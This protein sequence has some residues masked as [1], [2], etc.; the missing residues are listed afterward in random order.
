TLLNCLVSCLP[1]VQLLKSSD[2]GRHSLL[3]LKEIGHGWFGKV[4]LGEVNTELRSS[5]VVVKELKASASVQDQTLFLEEAQAYRTLQHPALMRCLA[6]CTEVTPYLLVMELCPLGDVKGYL[7]SCRAANTLTPEPLLLQ[8]MAC[9][10]ASGLLHLHKH[11]FVHGDLA[12]RNCLLAADVT[13][14]IGDYGLSHSKYKDDYYVTSDQMYVPLRWVAPELIDEVHGNLLVAD[15]T[16]QSNIWSLGVTI[17]ELFELGNQPYEHYSD[18]QV[19]TYALR[20]QQLRLPKPLLTVPLAERWYEVMQFCWLPADQRPNAEEV[21]L[22][23]SYLCAKG[24]SEAEEAEAEED[25][26]RRWDSLRP[27]AGHSGLHRPSS[28]SSYPLLEHF[29]T[30]DG[31]QG[32]D[33]L[34][35]TET[36]H[37]LNF[38]YKWEQA[39]AEP[40]FHAASSGTLGQ[41][42]PHCQDMYYPPGG[43]VGGCPMEGLSLGVSPS[44]YEPKQLHPPGVV[45]VLSA[46]SPSM[47][48]KYYIRI[49]EP[50]DCTID[51]DYTMCSY[52]PDYQGSSGSFLTGSADSGDCMACPPLAKLDS[53]WAS[54][55]HK[56]G[57]Y[58]SDASPAISLTMEPLLGHV[59]DGSPLRPW[60]SG[61]YVS[62]KDR[63]GGYYYEHSP[64]L[65]LDQHYLMG[66]EPSEVLQE[67]WG[68]RSLRQALGELENPL[69][70]S[71]SVGTP[72]QQ[73][74]GDPYLET[75]GG[76][77]IGKNVTGG[78]YDM[79]GSL[80]KTMPGHAH[81]VSI[82]MEKEAAIFIGHKDSDS[83]DEDEEDIFVERHNCN[84]WP[85]K[86][87]GHGSGGGLGLPRRRASCR[88]E[89]YADFHYTMPSTD[90]EDSWPEHSLAFHSALKPQH[91]LEASTKDSSSLGLGKH[92]P[93]VPAV[94]CSAYIYLCHEGEGEVTLP[95]ECCHSHFVDPLTGLVVRNYSH[96]DYTADKIVEIPSNDERV[97]LS[98]A[99][100]GPVVSKQT[101]TRK[102]DPPF[103]LPEKYVDVTPDDTSSAE[104]KGDVTKG[105]LIMEEPKVEEEAVTNVAPPPANTA[106]PLAT[107]EPD[108]ELS[109]TVDSGVDGSSISLVDVLD[110]S[111]DDDDDITDDITDVTSG[112][113]ADEA[114]D[115]ISSPVA[116]KPLQKQG[117]T[118]DSMESMDLPS[119]AG[120]CEG[121]SPAS[122]RPTSSPKAVDSGYDTENNESP[123]FVP[124]EPHEHRDSLTKPP[125]DISLMEE[126]EDVQEGEAEVVPSDGEPTLGEEV[127]ETDPQTGDQPLVPLSDKSPYRDSAYFSDYENERLSRDEGDGLLSK[128]EEGEDNVGEEDRREGR[129]IEEEE[130]MEKGEA[131]LDSDPE[132]KSGS[133]K[134]TELFDSDGPFPDS[135]QINSYLS[136]S[137]LESEGCLMEECAQHEGLGLGLE[138]PGEEERPECSISMGE[139]GLEEWPSQEESSSL[140]DWAAE[141]VGAMEEALGALSGDRCTLLNR[142]TEQK[143]VQETEEE[144]EEEEGKPAEME[145]PDEALVPDMLED[146]DES[147]ISC[148]E[149][150]SDSSEIVHRETENDTLPA[151]G[152]PPT[153]LPPLSSSSPPRLPPG[154]GLEAR[155]TADRGE[156]AD[157]EDGDT[158][159]SEESDEELRVYRV[160]DQSAGEE[161]EEE[162]FHPVPIV[163]SDCSDAH[164]LRSLLKMPALLTDT[165]CD[166][167]ERKRKVVSFFDDVTVYLFDQESPTKEL[168]EHGFPPVGE[169]RVSASQGRSSPPERVS[170]TSDD[171]SDGNISEES[172]GYEWED[173]F[174]LL[175]LSTSKMADSDS[176][177][178]KPSLPPTTK[179]AEPKQTQYSRFTVS[180]SSVNRFSITHVSDSDMDT[181]GGSSEEGERE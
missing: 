40:P 159:D 178:S 58:D 27:G 10:V 12:L 153:S 21:H 66:G 85:S 7:H 161:S 52:S 90:V 118:P 107:A 97:N 175:P 171:S 99:P 147:V 123:E 149:I 176:L 16:M 3:Y 24:A 33:I 126:A 152:S 109:Q 81:S 100:G 11:N 44:Y 112:I 18:R 145:D 113:F 43:M 15:Q 102:D 156:E 104:Q 134:A 71:P 157:E 181:A 101:L 105:D 47:G 1:S 61:H 17:W 130:E 94:D 51:L 9:D 42:N 93:L 29:S 167:L 67:S 26:E 141:V 179:V 110:C 13:V 22:L 31:Y 173:D 143:D 60:E 177:V 116:L 68:S 25:F 39:R 162:E 62:Y 180:P 138:L 150:Q 129:L 55:L 20:E 50:V 57:G 30:G 98:P 132:M 163:V 75:S 164:N 45:P 76:G 115:L 91:Y 28:S 23:L 79:M 56:T 124:K 48:S 172:A 92:H 170:H 80:R 87:S 119:G 142:S 154:E 32:D 72:S 117:G 5:Q 63:D 139:A 19:L 59:S 131:R 148:Y 95:G 34:T 46:H 166:D 69:G 2:L 83:E 165:L 121:L 77:V 106:V 41:G 140:G 78:Y 89:S 49:E 174:P 151:H 84:T 146:K 38:E 128:E 73:G 122:S 135:S 103:D 144:E 137:P 136:S 8:R 37:G 127:A 168:A 96:D 6:Q 70:I 169:S 54:N 14:K 114:G 120:S 35:V 133:L 82:N 88:Q 4:L 108:W 155:Q 65:G 111:D 158:D 125:L 53:Y 64:S 86:R 74:Y 160:Q 36:S